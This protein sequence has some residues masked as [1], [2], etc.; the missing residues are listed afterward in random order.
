MCFLSRQEISLYASFDISEVCSH[1]FTEPRALS[2]VFSRWLRDVMPSYAFVTLF[3]DQ[4]G[5]TDFQDPSRLSVGNNGPRQQEATLLRAFCARPS[6]SGEA[7]Q[8]QI[9]RYYKTDILSFTEL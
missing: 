1:S 4:N 2:R 3:W 6:A 9:F 7:Q 8:Q 5:G